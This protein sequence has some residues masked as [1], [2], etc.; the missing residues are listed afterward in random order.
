MNQEQEIE[1][2]AQEVID[3]FER[4]VGVSSIPHTK[5]LAGTREFLKFMVGREAPLYSYALLEA[6]KNLRPD[7]LYKGALGLS[8]TKVR[9]FPASIEA[10]ALLTLL[11]RSTR[12]VSQGNASRGYSIPYVPFRKREDHLLTQPANHIVRGRR[13]VGK[14]TLIRRATEILASTKALVCVLDMQTYSTLASDDLVREVLFDICNGIATSADRFG[15]VACAESNAL[16]LVANK[17]ASGETSASRAPVVIKRVM[18]DLTRIVVGDAFVFLD[19]FHLIAREAQPKLLHVIHAALKGSNGWL[20]VAGLSSLLNAYAP[21]EREGL[22]IPGDA[23]YVPLDLTLENPEAAE[24]HL[25]AILEGFLTAVGYTLNGTVLPDAAFR[26]LAWANAGVPRDFLQMFARSLEHASRNRHAAVTLSDVNV[27]IGEF[28]QQKMDDLQKDARY[29]A[30]KLRAMLE[31]L[32]TLCLEGQKI[33]AFL[34][35]SDNTPERAVIQILSDLR[36]VH[37]I[38]QSITPRRAGERFEAYILDYSLFTGFRRRPNV[39]EM[40]PKHLQFKAS[41]L[42]ALP[43]VPDSYFAVEL[44]NNGNAGTGGTF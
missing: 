34:I 30:G 17:I 33:N 16:K 13:G 26:R 3:A 7:N 37:L 25:R 14:S 39:K 24:T 23:Q 1:R 43:K 21:N 35:R 40:I 5:V 38:H 19:D 42:R 22:Q 12:E 31:K 27:A 20:K 11:T 36:M 8:V 41:E 2:D 9:N 28:G 32:E 4:E 44:S 15:N 29:V 18:S 6:Q 10:N